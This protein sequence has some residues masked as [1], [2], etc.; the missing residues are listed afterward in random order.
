MEGPPML[1]ALVPVTALVMALLVESA[2]PAGALAATP[3]QRCA[4]VKRKAA[5]KAAKGLAGCD[6]K[7]VLK[8][9][10]VDLACISHVGVGFAR[11]WSRA[12]RK[13]GCATIG[14]Q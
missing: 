11:A 2:I 1:H 4:A 7:A 12:E 5:G 8:G 6:G 9:V 10:G 13:G 3:A 14:D